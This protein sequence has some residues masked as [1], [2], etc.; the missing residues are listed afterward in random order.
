MKRLIIAIGIAIILISAL[1]VFK[2]KSQKNQSTNSADSLNNLEDRG[3]V[4]DSPY[5]LSIE[6]MRSQEYPGSEITIEQTLQSGSN[7]NKY[8]ASYKSDGLKIYALLTVPFG[9]PPAGGSW[10]VIIFNHGYIS[11]KEYSTT[12]K[13]IAYADAFSRNG[14]IVLKSD[15]RGHGNSEGEAIGGYG[16]PA[17]TIDVLNAVASIKKFEDADVNRIGMWGHSMGGF[18]TLRSMVIS[19]DIK[20]G[21]IWGG[22]VASYPDL[23]YNWRRSTFT[24]PPL[25]AGARR[26]RDLLV[27]QFGTPA[28]NPNFWNSISAN[29]YLKDVSGPI[30]LHHGTADASVPIAFSEKLDKEL[31]A[32]GKISELFIYRGD[33][34]NL[35]NNFNTAIQR[36]VDFFDKYLK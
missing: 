17:Y 10:P 23:I 8:I 26:W 24:P 34:H 12:G 20:A 22:V 27:A 28:E 14:Y 5:P 32:M 1:I 15:Y 29:A 36:S 11:P 25:S 19:K 7:Y 21:V 4:V 9:N 3:E 2:N 35:A 33:D 6:Y 16:S 18:I 30:Q 13:Y 31:K